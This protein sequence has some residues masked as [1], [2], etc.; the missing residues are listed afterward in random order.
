L[1]FQGIDG[2]LSSESQIDRHGN[3]EEEDEDGDNEDGNEEDE[4]ED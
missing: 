3:E 4:D 2:Q 1:K